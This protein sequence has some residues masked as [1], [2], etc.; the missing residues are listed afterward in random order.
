LKQHI[1]A[2]HEG[3]KPFKFDL[4]D[5]FYKTR[6]G[7]NLHISAI[8]ENKIFGC[9]KCGASFIQNGHLNIHNKTVHEEYNSLSCKTNDA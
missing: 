1:G 2:V 7:M 9:A 4:W 5:S 3:K 6:L 8:H